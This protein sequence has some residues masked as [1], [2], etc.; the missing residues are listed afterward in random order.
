MKDVLDNL[1]E[2]A[3]VWDE[4]AATAQDDD[5]NRKKTVNPYKTL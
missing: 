5:A 4:V 2:Q 3:I 1:K